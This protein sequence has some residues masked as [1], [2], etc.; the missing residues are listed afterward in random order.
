MEL[1]A[2]P[3]RYAGFLFLKNINF[4]IKNRNKVNKIEW[5]KERN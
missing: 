2:K 4:T 3:A 5:R 1:I